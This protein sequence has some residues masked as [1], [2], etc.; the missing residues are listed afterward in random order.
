MSLR[1]PGASLRG[2]LV[3]LQTGGRLA[4]AEPGVALRFDLAGIANRLDGTQAT[5]FPAPGGH[6]IAVVSG[7]LSQRAWMAE[8]AGVEQGELISAFERACRNPVPWAEASDAACQQAVE[9]DVDLGR[10]PIPPTTS[11]TTAPTSPPGC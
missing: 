7:L 3:H 8:A 9:R 11:T 1:P 4:L 6:D 2:W 10:L 5:V